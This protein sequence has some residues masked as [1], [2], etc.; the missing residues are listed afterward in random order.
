VFDSG[1]VSGGSNVYVVTAGHCL[2]GN[3]G[4]YWST[5]DAS[6]QER[7]N[8]GPAEEAVF[9]SNGDFGLI[10]ENGSYYGVDFVDS[11]F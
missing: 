4:H 3:L 11:I 7:H 5:V 1:V 2:K 6:T 10:K 9:G 8:L